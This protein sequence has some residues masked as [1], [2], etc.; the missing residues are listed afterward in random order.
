MKNIVVPS[1][2]FMFQGRIIPWKSL[3]K[4]CD[5]FSTH[6]PSVWGLNADNI[7][8]AAKLLSATQHQLKCSSARGLHN[9]DL[10]SY[11][12]CR[13]TEHPSWC[14]G[15]VQKERGHWSMC[16][17]LR[18]LFSLLPLGWC[19]WQP[20]WSEGHELWHMPVREERRLVTR[21]QKVPLW[22]WFALCRYLLVLFKA[23]VESR[24]FIV[25]G[26]VSAKVSCSDLKWWCENSWHANKV[27]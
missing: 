3:L 26:A 13:Q 7:S 14:V 10:C 27:Y 17:K 1:F 25:K 24:S 19:S 5:G 18:P 12:L 20:G 16:R 22:F 2:A 8:D 11:N 6:C 23:N 21:T 4:G 15:F 9:I